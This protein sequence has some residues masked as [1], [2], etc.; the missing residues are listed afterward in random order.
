[1]GTSEI[2]PLSFCPVRESTFGAEGIL[3]LR[4]FGAIV[5][6]RVFVHNLGHRLAPLGVEGLL[7][8]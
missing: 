1:M 8:L 5:Y 6:N 2:D 4:A 7:R 3:R